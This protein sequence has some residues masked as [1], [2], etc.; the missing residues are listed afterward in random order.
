MNYAVILAG[1]IGVRFNRTGI[2]KQ[3]VELVGM[4]MVVYSM[5]TAQNNSNID[6]ICVVTP[7]KSQ[8]QVKAWAEEYNI[9]KFS[10]LAT[11]GKERYQ[12]VYNGLQTIPAKKD[13]TVIIMTSVC[14]FLSQQTIDKHYELI[15]DYAGVITV[16]K[17]TDAITFSNDGKR[18]NRTLQK[19]RLF[20]QQ[21]PQTYRYGILKEAHEMYLADTD[22]TEVTEDSELVLNLGI[23]IGMVIGDRFCIKVTY[24]EDLA[25]AESL[26]GLFVNQ[27]QKYSER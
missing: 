13:D 26:Y 23:D 10:Y 11:S 14:P 3:F 21:G 20:V 6:K 2:P 24:P 27:E 8:Q 15:N 1:G 7:E 18:A 19:K 9:T 17:A 12:S 5:R 22:H 25:I 4:P 16:V